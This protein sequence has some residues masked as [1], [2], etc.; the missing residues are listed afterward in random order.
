MKYTLDHDWRGQPLPGPHPEISLRLLGGR[1]HLDL[2]APYWGDPAP[3]ATV[4]PCEGLWNY[5]V[6]ELFIAGAGTRY[7]ELELGPH[8]HHLFFGLRDIRRVEH[9]A[10]PLLELDVSKG[11]ERWRAHASFDGELL[12]PGPYRINLCAIRGVDPRE[13]RSL[14]ALPGE[15]PDFHQPD[16][17]RRGWPAL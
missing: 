17:W 16:L 6:V 13:Y 1:V 5:E 11:V 15:A 4:G 3:E 14:V 9:E 8:G 2:D 7:L 12:P 10:L